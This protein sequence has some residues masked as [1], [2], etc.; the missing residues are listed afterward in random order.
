M[1]NPPTDLTAFAR[2]RNSALDGFAEHGIAATSIRDVARAAGVSPG[3]VQHHFPNKVALR[4]AVDEYVIKPMVATFAEL[5]EVSSITEAQRQLGDR[6]TSVVRDHYT[7]LRYVTRLVSV[8]DPAGMR[9]FG[10]FVS[11]ARRQWQVVAEAGLLR[12]DLDLTWLAL[13]SVVIPLG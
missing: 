9:I 2:I 7:A 10:E 4:E 3:T 5:P 13:H 8:G 12:S 1:G 6:V 11:I